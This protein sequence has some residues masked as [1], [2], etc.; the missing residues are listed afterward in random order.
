MSGR[1]LQAF[2]GGHADDQALTSGRSHA[3][4]AALQ[5]ALLPT[6]VPVL[7]GLELGAAYR[8]ADTEDAAGGDWFDTVVLP[9]G[10]V[11]LVVGDVVGHG[12]V[13]S[14]V[15]SQLRAV[16]RHRLASGASAAEVVVDLDRLA[17]GLPGARCAT[18][19]VAT[20]DPYSGALRYCCAGHPPPLI[21]T[22]DG[23]G[24]RY[25]PLSG[26][27]P[28]ATGATYRDTTVGIGED[29]LVLL[30]T[31][32]IIERPGRHPGR[33]AAELAHVVAD[34]ASGHRPG[35]GVEDRRLVAQEV[36]DTAIDVLGRATGWRD[37]IVLLA[38][39]RHP[40]VGRMEL[41]L[42][43]LPMAVPTARA[44]LESW[45]VA[46]TIDPLVV[47]AIQHAVGEV[48][49]NAVEHAY[50]RGSDSS[51]TIRL[52]AELTRD[53]VV[54][55][56]VADRGRWRDQQ[57]SPYR[58]MGLGVAAEM[59]DRLDIDRAEDGTTVH[60][61]HSAGH[62]VTLLT[63]PS[64]SAASGDRPFIAAL[65]D[66][67]DPD[68]VLVIHGPVDTMTAPQLRTQLRAVT[69]NGTRTCAV[70]LTRVTVLTSAGVSVLH[71][72]SDRSAAQH[73]QLLLLAPSDSAAYHVL[74]LSGLPAVTEYPA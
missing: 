42:P 13:A 10:S 27:S 66:A 29:D 72:A 51:C 61:R 25:L 44:A 71:E 54:E 65:T 47:S 16:A 9:D 7:P 67:E 5:A 8:M 62:P 18:A 73:E 17:S 56:E 50:P 3:N 21:V 2:D 52:G 4:L 69:C 34:V 59:V 36:C 46:L 48:V 63:P 41:T 6:T 20:L 60:L 14:A 58:G 38:A 11:G 70:D 23:S 33:A 43:N 37:D 40:V 39:R 30:Y 45:L 68:A 53:G 24:D 12:V 49:T 15:M 31:D 1:E 74:T 57:A 22:S 35:T 26:A 55:V 19:C 32:G 64:T 28:L